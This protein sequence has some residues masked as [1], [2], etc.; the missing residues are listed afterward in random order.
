MATTPPKYIQYLYP[1]GFHVI[2]KQDSTLLTKYPPELH[3][4]LFDL[5]PPQYYPTEGTLVKI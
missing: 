3:T 4:L 1:S 5:P 2:K